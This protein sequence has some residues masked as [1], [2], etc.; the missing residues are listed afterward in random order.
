MA[1][2]HIIKNKKEAKIQ[3]STS[4]MKR[5]NPNWDI[6]VR[7][8]IKESNTQHKEDKTQ[9]HNIKTWAMFQDMVALN[10]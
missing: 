1:R 2:E 10:L 8:L 3:Y 6:N 7:V 9:P 5:K 4:F